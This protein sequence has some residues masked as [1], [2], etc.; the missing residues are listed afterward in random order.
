MKNK[1][2]ILGLVSAVF[3][4]NLVFTSCS[5][6]MEVE[7]YTI[8]EKKIYS[9]EDSVANT[10]RTK[11]AD[12]HGGTYYSRTDSAHSFGIGTYIIL[13]DTNINKDLRVVIDYWARVNTIEPGY[14]FAVSVQD[15]GQ[16]PVWLELDPKKQIKA[17]NTWTHIVDSVTIPGDK[18]IKGG[19]EI[20]A[21][22]YNPNNAAK[23]IV[24]DGDDLEVT[25]K[26]VEIVM[27]D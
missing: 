7:K 20:K 19:M 5:E 9:C 22:A 25:F 18:L 14:T 8:I 24:F 15:A 12:A 10:E 4:C 21:F 6:P 27:E 2:L 1:S 3:T 26:K 17:V 23:S 11:G 16:V 13:S